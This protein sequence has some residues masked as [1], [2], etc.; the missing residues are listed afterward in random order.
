MH[1]LSQMIDTQGWAYHTMN[2]NASMY[3][4]VQCFEDLSHTDCLLCFA[5]SRTKL[6]RCLPA[7]S[8]RIYLD[9]CFLR[10]DNYSFYGESVDPVYDT[11]NCSTSYGWV[12]H[13]SKEFGLNVGKVVDIV[14]RNAVLYGGFGVASVEG[15]VEAVEGRAMNAGCYLRYSTKRFYNHDDE[16]EGNQKLEGA[17]VITAATLAAAAIFMFLVFVAYVGYLRYHTMRREQHNLEQLPGFIKLNFKC[18]RKRFDLN[19]RYETLEKA[20]NYFD[21]W[22]KLGE[23]G[24]GVVFKAT[25]PDGR[26]VAVKWLFFN[27]RDWTDEFF[28]EVNLISGI[29]HKNLVKLLGCSIEGPESLLVYEYVP[30]KSLDIHTFVPMFKCNTLLNQRASAAAS[31]SGVT[32]HSSLLQDKKEGQTLDW[33]KRLNI[34]VG[35]AEGLA[36]LHGGTPTRM[37]HRDIK[38]SNVLLGE[39][40]TPK[41]AD[42]GLVR[43]YKAPEYLLHGQLTDKA[44]VYSFGVWNLYRLNRLLEAMDRRLRSKFPVKE[45][46]KVL[47]IGLLRTQA[48]SSLRPSMAQAVLMLTDETCEIPTPNQPPFL[49]A[50]LLTCPVQRQE[51][52]KST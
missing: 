44:D 1:S 11:S 19:F 2:T 4:P 15:E 20:T 6:P 27:T 21:P 28:N 26:T 51:V 8:A 32:V 40:F 16:M 30:N 25:L 29:Q 12:V 50:S 10:Y 17:G 43:G 45:A 14:T 36:H 46:A 49:K 35:T 41:I 24:A 22:K 33:R 3:G 9:G 47:Q 48:S 38:S 42:F 39:D 7:L 37:I 52:N 34:I 31:C 23:G 18:N 5:A 13:Q